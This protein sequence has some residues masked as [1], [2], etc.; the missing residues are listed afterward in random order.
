VAGSHSMWNLDQKYKQRRL[1]NSSILGNNQSY[2][3]L[4]A[5]SMLEKCLAASFCNEFHLAKSFNR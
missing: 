1:L 3:L 2:F 5:Y 4:S